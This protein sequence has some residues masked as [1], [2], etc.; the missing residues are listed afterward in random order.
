[1]IQN[2]NNSKKYMFLFMLILL[3]TATLLFFIGEKLLPQG[4]HYVPE[5]AVTVVVILYILWLGVCIVVVRFL[6]KKIKL[7]LQGFFNVIA[8]ILTFVATFQLPGRPP[9]RAV[10]HTW[11][12]DGIPVGWLPA[13]SA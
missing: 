13:G 7:Y 5:S 8:I 3:F 9:D 11:S 10:P 2:K 6:L 1:M 12:L 4:W